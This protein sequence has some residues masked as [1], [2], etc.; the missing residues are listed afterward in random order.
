MEFERGEGGRAR[1]ERKIQFGT[2]YWIKELLNPNSNDKYFS[3]IKKNSSPI[4]Y[5][6]YLSSSLRVVTI[7]TPFLK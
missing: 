6:R 5:I 3:P 4:L 2:S 1:G 7:L